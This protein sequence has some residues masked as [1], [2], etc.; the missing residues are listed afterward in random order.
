[1]E[2]GRIGKFSARST[3]ASWFNASRKAAREVIPNFGNTRYRCVPTVRGDMYNCS[4]ICLFVMPVA[5][6]LAISSSW[7]VND[8]A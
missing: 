4:P 6:R 7:G 3:H 5:A 8:S 1:M 2:C